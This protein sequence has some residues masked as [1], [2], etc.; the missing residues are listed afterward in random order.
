MQINRLILFLLFVLLPSSLF[1]GSLGEVKTIDNDAHL[2]L[3][4]VSRNP[5]QIIKVKIYN[6]K[7]ENDEYYAFVKTDE[8]GK[9]EVSKSDIDISRL[10][11]GLITFE[12]STNEEGNSVEIASFTKI[13]DKGLLL[14]LF[15]RSADEFEDDGYVN[16]YEAA[17]YVLYGETESNIKEL[18]ISISDSNSSTMSFTLADAILDEN[19]TFKIENIDLNKLRDGK[20]KVVANAL[21]IAGN[22]VKVEFD[23]I[24]D[25]VVEQPILLKKI[26]NNNLSNVLNRK[27]LVASG[28]SEAN[29]VIYF[30][31]TQDEVIVNESVNANE[32]GEWELLGADLDVSVF[33][34]KPVNVSI[35][36]IDVAYNK[37]EAF[38]YIN[39]KFKRPIFPLT[40]IAIDPLK[41]Q[42]I[43][44]I[45]GNTDEI[46]DIYITKTDIFVATYGYVKVWGKSYAKLQREVEIKD[47][48]VN[49]ILVH[50]SKVF[51]GLGNGNI[52]V[53]E[54][55]TLKLLKIIKVDELGVLKMK[56]SDNKL[57]ASTASGI[58]KIFDTN[59]FENTATIKEH[60]W[61]VSAIA[62][63]D[64]KLYSGSDDYS[65]NIFDLSTLKLIKS[66]KS[67]HAGTINDIIIYNDM[68]ISASDDKTIVI[69]DITTGEKIRVLK[70]HKKA[71][72]KL[73]I[74][75]DFLISISSDRSMIFW[76]INSGEI[77]KKIKAHAKKVDA[78]DVNDYNIVTG[79]RDY[80][81]KIWGY[82]DSVEALDDEDETKKAKYSLIKSFK[83][84]KGV[85]TSLSQNENDII[86]SSDNGYILFYNK[87][88]HD[89]VKSYSTLDE[90]V[91]VIAKDEDAYEDDEESDE[92]E[93][94]LKLQKVYA[95]ANFGN[96]L[97]CGLDDS[98]IKVWD[99]ETNKATKLLVGSE[100]AITDIKLSST[101]ILA[102]S[103]KGNIGVYDIDTG[104]F[105]N[106]IEGHQ[107][108]VNTIA[109]Y[110]DDKVVSAG[111]DYSIK[112]RDIET[113][114]MILDIKNAHD[115][116]ITKVLVYNNLLI[117]ASLDKTIK[118]RNILTG[119]LIKILEAHKDGVTSLVLDDDNLISSS[120]DKT[121]IAWSIKDFHLISVMDK[122]KS[123]VV[124]VMITDDYIISISEDKTI[125]VWK[126]YE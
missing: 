104:S 88:T 118:V 113:G 48:W 22:R 17:T 94:E 105:I 34:N 20:L 86:I 13:L 115:D 90:I 83:M 47:V 117:S 87:I 103:K 95:T 125:K 69:R 30:E 38:K 31:F 76:D 65:I 54:E 81:I 70:A 11:D 89:Y 45:T 71:V 28:T 44:T 29:A 43:Y 7:Y 62:I 5:T 24:K 9:F 40:P 41:Y 23:L 46:K 33:K 116:V 57:I 111:D 64:G 120:K 37:S 56:I 119:K 4:G 10:K 98:T 72:N 16:S 66:I 93:Y 39:Q 21:D 74:N 79:S 61:D 26:K 6:T 49:T 2:I 75:T 101:N 67:A 107:Y 42:L 99:M 106:L 80:K 18:Q 60:Q 110:E 100:L 3:T 55:D 27:I 19:A 52:N 73:K 36:Q 12:V 102:S 91:K 15:S 77:L 35:Y 78:I 122:H 68:I 50:D 32:K 84:K 112:I 51:A 59:T 53:Y 126:Y 58:I 14:K 85:P 1:G 121:L 25:T 123:A 97:L 63:G 92:K 96:Q 108:N 124:D 114:D 109:V 82:D 8:A